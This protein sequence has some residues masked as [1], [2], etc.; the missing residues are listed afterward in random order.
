MIRLLISS[1]T[2]RLYLSFFNMKL[3]KLF[4]LTLR[5][6]LEF[7]FFTA[8]VY[9]DTQ[10]FNKHHIQHHLKNSATRFFYEVL[11]LL[12]FHFNEPVLNSTTEF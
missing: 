7:Y 3:F 8:T 1:M 10:Y 4:I 9:L 5:Y 12:R 6:S 11:G 2:Y